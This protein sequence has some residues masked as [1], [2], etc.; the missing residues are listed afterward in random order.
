MKSSKEPSVL[1]ILFLTSF[2]EMLGFGIAIPILAPL[3]LK[4]S[5]SF[6]PIGT[7]EELRSILYGVTVALFPFAQIFGT[8]VLGSLSDH[9][10]RK[11]VLLLSRIGTL[12]SYVMIAVGIATGSFIL[13]VLARLLDG[14]TGGNISVVQS[15]VSDITSGK[16]RS[17]GFGMIGMAFGLGFIFGPVLG[18][19]LS[20]ASVHPSFSFSTP[21]WLAAFVTLLNVIFVALRLPETLK[22]KKPMDLHPLKS[23]T[24][25]FAGFKRR[26]LRPLLLVWFFQV[27]GFNFFTQFFQVF[28]LQ[29]FAVSQL[30]IGI[31]FG[32]TGLWIAVAQGFTNR[33]LTAR[34]S[35]ASIIMRAMPVLSLAMLALLLP[36]KYWVFFCIMPFIANAQGACMPNLTSVLSS[37]GTEHEQGEILGIG[38]SVQSLGMTLPP[39][40]AGFLAA[41][42][43]ELPLIAAAGFIAVAWGLF[44]AGERMLRNL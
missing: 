43:V 37:R 10:G 27:M 21:F 34:L 39:L 41:I 6:L 30:Q 32:Y 3:F 29:K 18:G 26:D 23:F 14:F 8:P 19:I 20:D 40:L 17:R 11:P 36:S 5:S 33:L 31:L 25:S 44:V 35:S 2:F 4:E 16:E 38:Q 15:A 12:A 42:S 28:L 7:G 24:R 13:I 1:G 22:T 9:F